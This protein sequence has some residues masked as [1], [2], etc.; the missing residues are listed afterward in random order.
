MHRAEL[1]IH[2][3]MMLTCC[4]FRLHLSATSTAHVSSTS[5]CTDAHA[6][7]APVQVDQVYFPQLEVVGDVGNAIWRISEAIKSKPASWDLRYD[8][9]HP[10]RGPAASLL[11]NLVVYHS[12]PM[13]L[14]HAARRMPS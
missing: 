7:A 14:P 9:Y 2:I 8:R 13:S 10:W 11:A 3:L 4:V 12:R 5:L 6:V 1:P